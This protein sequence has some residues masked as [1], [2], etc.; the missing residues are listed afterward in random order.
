MKCARGLL[1]A[2]C[3][4]TSLT[5]QGTVDVQ[6]Q[7]APDPGTLFKQA[8]I[9]DNVRS[10]FD[11]EVLSTIQAMRH[12]KPLMLDFWGK[13]GSSGELKGELGIPVKDHGCVV[14]DNA[15]FARSLAKML[16]L[17]W[18]AARGQYPANSTRRA[19][20]ATT[21][22]IPSGL[23]WV[24]LSR[25][26]KG[27][28]IEKGYL[29]LRRFT[30]NGLPEVSIFLPGVNRAISFPWPDPALPWDSAEWAYEPSRKCF[31]LRIPPPKGTPGAAVV[32]QLDDSSGKVIKRFD[33]S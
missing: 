29:K 11:A 32:L 7:D 4:A 20:T 26:V 25:C 8:G 33:E 28:P 17:R 13:P 10:A 2:L 9:Q 12:R 22:G 3:L 27:Q 23:K 1:T 21:D 15:Q 5:V 16:V 14:E 6:A 18:Y 24:H 19:S 30:G 31:W